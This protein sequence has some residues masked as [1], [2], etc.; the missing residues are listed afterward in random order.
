[1]SEAYCG[2]IEEKVSEPTSAEERKDAVMLASYTWDHQSGSSFQRLDRE[3][4]EREIVCAIVEAENAAYDR[5]C[6][7]LCK[8]KLM[9]AT[10][11]A[12]ALAAIRA[13][14]SGGSDEAKQDAAS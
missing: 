6:E 5:V 9:G 11:V 2:I 4:L 1:M 14:K 3:K 10:D 8:C 7:T 12:E 13:L